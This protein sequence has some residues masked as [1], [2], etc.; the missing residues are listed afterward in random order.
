MLGPVEP[1]MRH[2]A[3]VRSCDSYAAFRFVRSVAMG[4]HN[5]T[6]ESGLSSTIHGQKRQAGSFAGYVRA[7]LRACLL[8]VSLALILPALASDGDMGKPGRVD[9]GAERQL[10]DLIN[11]SR[12]AEGLPPLVM[13]QR[14]T[15]AARKHTVRMVQHK[16]LSHQ[17][18]DENPLPLRLEA[19]NL[20]SD[21]QAENIALEVDIEGA[22][23]SLMRSPGHRANILNPDYNA[24]GVGIIRMGNDVYVTED[25]AHRLPDYSE[26][27]AD[28]FLQHTIEKFATDRG[29]PRPVRKPQASLRRAACQMAL[30][31]SLDTDKPL[32]LPGAHGVLEWTA[33]DLE[34]LPPNAKQLLAQP[35]HSAYSLGVCFAPSVSHA[36]GLY[37]V[38]MV[39]Y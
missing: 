15:L 30:N 36:G 22:H 23:Q 1:W 3:P 35:L 16:E 11:Q 18:D 7:P 4:S 9:E 14:L 19:E 33:S 6:P 10:I 26:H 8:L 24:V 29:L 39:V 17:Y 25:F 2:L 38:V 28:A 34:K 31:D 21:R 12:N 32:G 13:D 27:E 5:T 37:W 20:R